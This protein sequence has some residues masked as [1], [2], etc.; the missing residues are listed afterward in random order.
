MLIITMLTNKI[1][2][3]RCFILLKLLIQVV[4]FYFFQYTPIN[5]ISNFFMNQMNNSVG[6]AKY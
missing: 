5:I 3:A 6:N 1:I 2:N 4:L